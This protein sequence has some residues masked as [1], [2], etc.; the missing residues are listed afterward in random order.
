MTP[1]I[2]AKVRSILDSYTGVN[3]DPD[4]PRA[5]YVV[6]CRWVLGEATDDE[7]LREFPDFTI[8]LRP[9]KRKGPRVIVVEADGSE[10]DVRL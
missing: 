8:A 10:R 2:A 5:E 6:W 9:K 3:E 7:L 1:A 4:N